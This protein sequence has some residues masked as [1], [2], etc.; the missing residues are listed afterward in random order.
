MIIFLRHLSPKLHQLRIKTYRHFWG[1]ESIYLHRCGPFLENGLDRPENRYGRYG[2]ASCSS[3]SISTVG[4]DRHQRF[5]LK[6]LF[7]C[8]LGG[9]GGGTYFKVPCHIILTVLCRDCSTSLI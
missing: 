8:S 7:S 4:V 5:A 6:I 9:G 1:N 2:F 3:I